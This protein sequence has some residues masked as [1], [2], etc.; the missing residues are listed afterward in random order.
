MWVAAVGFWGWVAVLEFCLLML[1]MLLKLDVYCNCN[2]K[3]R[4][5]VEDMIE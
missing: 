5:D 1:L 3:L 4:F 2:L